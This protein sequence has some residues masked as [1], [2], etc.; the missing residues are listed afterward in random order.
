MSSR[1]AR[2]ITATTP[3]P[4]PHALPTTP[5][6]VTRQHWLDGLRGAAVL[7]M[8][9]Y[10][11]AYDLNFLG[12]LHQD[13]NHDL[14][15]R[16]AR[17]LILGSFL[18][19]VGAA[20]ALATH[21]QTPAAA[22]W[23]RIGKIAAA[24]LLVTLGS[25]LLF[26]QSIIWFGVLHAITLM[27]LLLIALQKAR[28]DTARTSLLFG[29]IALILGN[30]GSHPLFDSPALAWLGLMTHAPD[31]ED[32]VP[33]L[34]W[35]GLCLIG[36]GFMMWRLQQSDRPDGTKSSPTRLPHS[37][38]WLGRHSLAIYLL[39]QPILLAIL[40]PLRRWTAA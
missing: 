1:R 26:P 39:H 3:A 32:Y 6:P 29:F 27:S 7:A 40:I 30:V 9:A 35:F 20:Q 19:S 8:I 37:L 24:A 15:W 36:H 25:A 17:S 21:Q 12:W 2:R 14:R 33:L 23:R 16:I 31:T 38:L 4:R 18:F 34:P 10:H 22:R 28:L 13:M 11:A 5:P